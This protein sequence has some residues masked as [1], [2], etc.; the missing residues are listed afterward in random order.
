M[1]FRSRICEL[2]VSPK[3]YLTDIRMRHAERYLAYTSYTLRFIANTCGFHDEFHFSK[4]FH[5]Y[6]GI[7]PAE[8]R[9]TS[10]DADH[11][12]L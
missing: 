8:F 4:A 12:A 2:H 11:S 5:K 9:K 7:A 10:K 6:K 1:P 3:D